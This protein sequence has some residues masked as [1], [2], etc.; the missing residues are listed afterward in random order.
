MRRAQ[1]Q[2]APKEAED[3]VHRWD[4]IHSQETNS[5]RTAHPNQPGIRKQ[6]SMQRSAQLED[7]SL[8]A[9][10]PKA[11]NWQRHVECQMG[12]TQRHTN[13]CGFIK[14]GPGHSK[15]I[16]QKTA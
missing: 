4:F 15:F 10:D 16:S 8:L 14:P 11:G 2:P 9:E 6:R 13:L 7:P 1:P 12:P 5:F 3:R